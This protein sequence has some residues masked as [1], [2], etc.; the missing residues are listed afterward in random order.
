VLANLLADV[1][2]LA[3]GAKGAE[4]QGLPA[5]LIPVNPGGK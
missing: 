4:D 3:G 2:P 5:S 1:M